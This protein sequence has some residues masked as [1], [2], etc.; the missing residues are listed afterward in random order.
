MHLLLAVALLLVADAPTGER[1]GVAPD[2]KTYPQ[3]T[4]KEALASVFKAV[5]DKRIDYLVA[6][7]ADPQYI[8]ERVQRLYGGKVAGQVEETRTRFDAG[9]VKLL[10]RFL[11][12]GEWTKGE[13]SESVRLKDS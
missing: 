7:L 5:E 3:S 13:K 11:K 4:P 1:Y 8:D 2:L 12:D 10:Q 9:T 6:Q